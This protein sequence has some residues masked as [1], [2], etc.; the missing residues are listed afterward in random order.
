MKTQIEDSIRQLLNKQVRDLQQGIKRSQKALSNLAKRRRNE[1]REDDRIQVPPQWYVPAL[2]LVGVAELMLNYNAFLNSYGTPFFAGASAIVVALTVAF[3]SHYHG[4]A[5]K[6]W[7]MRFHSSGDKGS[8]EDWTTLW[9]TSIFLLLALVW[10]GWT[11]YNWVEDLI[12]RGAEGLNVLRTVLPTMIANLIVWF[13]GFMIAIWTHD[14]SPDLEEDEKL[15][16]KEIANLNK[17]TKKFQNTVTNCRK[18]FERA[19][20][21]KL[22]AAKVATKESIAQVNAKLVDLD[23]EIHKDIFDIV[24]FSSQ[25]AN[26]HE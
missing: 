20:P 24:D 23:R 13:I 22:E 3:A 7:E 9:V 25:R 19:G 17:V 2:V 12:A 8:R 16:R 14:R 10:I 1:G 5:A 21:E 6:Q 11:R 4:T 18:R 15:R 26:H